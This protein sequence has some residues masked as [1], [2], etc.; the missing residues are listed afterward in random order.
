MCELLGCPFIEQ[1]L[2]LHFIHSGSGRRNGYYV[3]SISF[4]IEHPCDKVVFILE[5][6]IEGR[7]FY[8][9]G[10]ADF[11][12]TDLADGLVLHDLPHFI[13]DPHLGDFSHIDLHS[14]QN[15]E[16]VRISSI[17]VLM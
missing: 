3:R 10:L 8:F 16:T 12:Y 9:C 14:L 1:D 11:C 13:C 17:I 15:Y 4:C 2:L 5:V 6:I 7:P